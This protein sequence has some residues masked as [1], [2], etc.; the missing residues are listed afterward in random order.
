MAVH[1]LAELAHDQVVQVSMSAAYKLF[2]SDNLFGVGNSLEGNYLAW[3]Y[4]SSTTFKLKINISHL[5]F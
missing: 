2:L 5:L 4:L 1:Y 3:D